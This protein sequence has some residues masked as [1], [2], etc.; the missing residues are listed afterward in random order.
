MKKILALIAIAAF[1]AATS[2]GFSE[3]K[4][5]EAHKCSDA[6]KDK[7]KAEHKCSDACKDKCA[8]AK[9]EGEKK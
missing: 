8:T 2:T 6:C 3:E 1:I 9:K 4:A 7:C 5:K